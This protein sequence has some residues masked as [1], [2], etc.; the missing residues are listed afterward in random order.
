MGRRQHF[1]AQYTRACPPASIFPPHSLSRVSAAVFIHRFNH[2]PRLFCCANRPASLPYLCSY[3]P[4]LRPPSSPA[5]LLAT[6]HRL[7]F[8]CHLLPHDRAHVS[9]FWGGGTVTRL[10]NTLLLL[11]LCANSLLILSMAIASRCCLWCDRVYVLPGWDTIYKP[12]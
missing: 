10:R 1:P 7:F 2:Y 9:L 5:P 4:R 8:S 12:P 6:R 11:S 3:P